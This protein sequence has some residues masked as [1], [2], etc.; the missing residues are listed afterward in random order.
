[1][2]GYTLFLVTVG[3]ATMTRQL[4]RLVDKIEY[5]PRRGRR[6]VRKERKA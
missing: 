1:M 6:E 3:A 5:P 4:F 2:D